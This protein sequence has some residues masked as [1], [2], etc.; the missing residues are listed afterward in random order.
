MLAAYQSNLSLEWLK[1]LGL[2]VLLQD[3][4]GTIILTDDAR[5]LE[6]LHQVHRQVLLHIILLQQL[7]LFLERIVT[8]QLCRR[9]DFL[10]HSG[11]FFGIALGLGSS[12]LAAGLE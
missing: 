6:L 9:L 2:I 7:N 11:F 4:V 1:Y 12:S 10:L 3:P 5:R 8:G